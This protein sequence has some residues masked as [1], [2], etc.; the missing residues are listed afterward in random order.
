MVN[1]SHEI[2][3]DVIFDKYFEYGLLGWIWGVKHEIVNI[4]ANMELGL[5][6]WDGIRGGGV[7][8]Y[9][10]KEAGFMWWG[11]EENI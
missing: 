8:K 1:I 4:E 7:D 5:N 11:I 9:T 10:W 2:E 6:D 3:L